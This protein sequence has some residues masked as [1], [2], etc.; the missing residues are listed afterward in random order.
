MPRIVIVIAVLLVSAP[1]L[2]EVTCDQL[3]AISQRAIDLRNEGVS[4]SRV[5]TDTED[6]TMKQRFTA[7]ELDFIRLLIRE[8]FMGAYSPYDVKEA[9][10]DGR[11]A[12]PVRKSG[13][14]K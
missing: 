4:L 13:K 6:S 3:V 9:C 1:A 2:A 7:I 12:I 5:L 10:E 11:L 8:S 14:T